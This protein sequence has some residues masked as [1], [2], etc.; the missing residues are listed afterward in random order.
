VMRGAVVGA[1]A[2]A[3]YCELAIG[4]GGAIEVEEW[5]RG[6]INLCG[7]SHEIT[8]D[9]VFI[10]ETV[11]YQSEAG[12]CAP[13]TEGTYFEQWDRSRERSCDY[14]NRDQP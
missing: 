6:P 4:A 3:A 8:C 14:R 5:L 7:L 2:T 13:Y 9:S 11:T 1:A 10:S 12:V